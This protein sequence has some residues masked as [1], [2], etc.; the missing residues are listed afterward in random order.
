MHNAIGMKVN[1]VYLL[2]YFSCVYYFH[3]YS[4]FWKY[5]EYGKIIR[6]DSDSKV[7]E[8][9]TYDVSI[10][11]KKKKKFEKI[12]KKKKKEKLEVCFNQLM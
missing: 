3:Y 12:E 2:V 8:F 10:D 1:I 9:Y 6:K 7:V 5:E 11:K 4:Y